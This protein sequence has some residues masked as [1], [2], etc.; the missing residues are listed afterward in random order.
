TVVDIVNVVDAP[1]V[2][3]GGVTLGATQGA[4]FNGVL[5]TFSDVNTFITAGDFTV[6]IDWGDG[7]VTAGTVTTAPG[8]G[9][10]VIGVYVY[11]VLGPEN[12]SITIDDANGG[13]TT[14]V[15]IVNIVDA[16][17]VGGGGVT[18]G[19][20]QGAGFNGVLATF[21]DANAFITADDFTATIDWGDG[22]VS[23]GTVT[24]AP[25]GGFEVIGAYV[26]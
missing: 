18:L 8:G 3:G 26:Y 25:G 15:D 1:I 19:A 13:S 10:E 4:G 17:I 12:I 11:A 5:A 14:V 20:T 24:T 9:F 6:T 7:T 21:S 23:T 2:G 22:A 16:P